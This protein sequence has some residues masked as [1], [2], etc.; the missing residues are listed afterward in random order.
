METKFQSK[1]WFEEFLFGEVTEVVVQY[2]SDN[3]TTTCWVIQRNDVDRRDAI[4]KSLNVHRGFDTLDPDDIK[5]DQV[6]NVQFQGVC[7]RGLVLHRLNSSEVWV[8][9][10]D[11]GRS[12]RARIATIRKLHQ[13][14]P[15]DLK[16]LAF[17]INFETLRSIRIDEVLRVENISHNSDGAIDVRFVADKKSFTDKDIEPIPLPVNVPLEMFCLDYSN[18]HLGYISVCQND[19]KKIEAVS[20][21]SDQ[22]SRCCKGTGC[23]DKNYC[24]KL[25]ELCLAY[26]EDD[27][28]WYRSKCVENVM[29]SVYR[30]EMIDY[31][32]VEEVSM[33]NIRR[34]TQDFI[35]PPIIKHH[36]TIFGKS[37]LVS[38]D[39]LNCFLISPIFQH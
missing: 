37:V 13:M 14:P 22:I 9:L 7:H 2:F 12:F 16:G 10:I 15:T 27:G 39:P 30:L 24:P 18:I 23:D 8:R 38:S 11:N 17:E 4:S 6:Y 31:G 19:R 29:P 26:T 3:P 21:I 34:M 1:K 33:K 25:N 28:Q 20:E 36:C 35:D 5:L 32:A